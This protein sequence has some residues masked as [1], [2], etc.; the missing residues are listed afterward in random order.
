MC[1][2]TS[3]IATE[4]SD[5]CVYIF[6]WLQPSHFLKP[7]C[8]ANLQFCSNYV[9]TALALGLFQKISSCGGVDGTNCFVLRV[10]G[11][12]Q[13]YALGM[14]GVSGGL[15]GGCTP[16]ASWGWGVLRFSVSWWW[17]VKIIL[18]STP[19]RII[20]G[21]ALSSLERTV[22]RYSTARETISPKSASRM[23]PE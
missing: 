10:E 6:L 19:L 1:L 21:T 20:S 11:S 16:A 23:V 2:H 8:C 18:P 7:H 3:M 12:A 22:Y 9:L 14:V 4:T 17:G 13:F 15:W 5:V